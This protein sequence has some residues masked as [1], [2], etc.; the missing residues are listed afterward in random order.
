MST[1]E[2]IETVLA[3]LLSATAAVTLYRND[4][5]A[6]DAAHRDVREH[7][8]RMDTMRAMHEASMAQLQRGPQPAMFFPAGD[9]RT[10]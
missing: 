6:R 8:Y 3:V 1:F 5:R 2:I 10:N 7:Q 4:R 9:P